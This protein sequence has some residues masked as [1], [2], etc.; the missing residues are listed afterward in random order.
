MPPERNPQETKENE[1]AEKH[2]LDPV[3]LQLRDTY[4]P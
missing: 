4:P 1:F 3:R 2:H